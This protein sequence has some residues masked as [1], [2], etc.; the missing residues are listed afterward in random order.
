MKFVLVICAV[1]GTSL[2]FNEH[3]KNLRPWWNTTQKQGRIVGGFEISIEEVPW[4]VSLFVYTHFCGGCIIGSYWVLT[5]GHCCA[6][7]DRP[8]FSIRAGSSNNYQGG[9]EV[10]VRRSIRHPNYGSTRRFDYDFALLELAEGLSFTH[11][12]QAIKLPRQGERV[13]AGA[14]CLLSGWGNTQNY[15]DDQSILRAANLPTVGYDDCDQAYYW[16]GGISPRMICA[17]YWNGGKGSCQG[18]SG[19]PLVHDG[20]LIGVVSWGVGCA[21]EGHPGVYGRV[22]SVRDWIQQVSGI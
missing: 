22:A 6:S 7:S 16:Q 8:S 1:L 21:E 2:A 3:P 14:M 4:Q 10:R 15:L 13:V 11:S 12:V 20:K 17:G 18:D 9:R 19:G 5:A